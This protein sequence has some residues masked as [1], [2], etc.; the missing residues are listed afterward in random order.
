MKTIREII[1]E[2]IPNEDISVEMVDKLYEYKNQRVI[3]ELEKLKEECTDVGGYNDTTW[4]VMEEDIDKRIKELKPIGMKTISL[5]ELKDEHLGEIGTD[6]RDAHEAEVAFMT[7][8][9]RPTVDPS[10]V[11]KSAEGTEDSK[12][13]K[14]FT[15]LRKE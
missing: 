1:G 14:C 5:T 9:L 3:E 2:Y 15:K 4:G 11:M 7:R 12:W 6:K 10:K 13:W 8:H